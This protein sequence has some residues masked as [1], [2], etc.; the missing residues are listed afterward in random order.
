LEK[1]KDCI[2]NSVELTDYILD[3]YNDR[4]IIRDQRINLILSDDNEN[5]V[6]ESKTEHIALKYDKVQKKELDMEPGLTFVG[7]SKI[8]NQSPIYTINVPKGY[9]IVQKINDL[10]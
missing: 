7:Y 6:S 10:I 2:W 4:L 9:T 5:M 8:D 1:Y 3:M